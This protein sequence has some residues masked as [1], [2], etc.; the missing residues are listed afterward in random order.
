MERKN[1]K[2]FFTAKNIAYFAVLLALVIVLQVFASAI[3]VGATGATLNFSLVPIVLGALLL[4]PIG[5]TLLGLACGIVVLVQVV[6]LTGNA[7][8]LAIWTN[9]PVVTT[10]TCLIKTTAAGFLAGLAY[11]LISRKNSLAAAFV[12]SAIVPIVNTGIFILGCL[13]MMGTIAD[14]GGVSGIDILVFILVGIV[15]F[16]FFI[17]LAI[18][19]ILTPAIHRVVLIVEKQLG[20]KH[21]APA[22]ENNSSEGAPFGEEQD[23]KADDPRTDIT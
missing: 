7:F 22:T 9:S 13:C 19:L 15:S 1:L 2:G 8:Y 6:V 11:K 18:N 16:N 4:G 14:F 5:G 3:P 10:F 20:R 12:A 17:E 23:G 21:A